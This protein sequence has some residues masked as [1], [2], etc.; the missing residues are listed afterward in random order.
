MN[1]DRKRRAIQKL[2]CSEEIRCGECGASSRKIDPA[3]LLAARKARPG[4]TGLR[5]ATLAGITEGALNALEHGK[6][7][8]RYETIEK[9]YDGLMAY[10]AERKAC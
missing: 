6:R 10:D 1:E 8:T 2:L 7:G 3:K 9:I 5:L 4:L